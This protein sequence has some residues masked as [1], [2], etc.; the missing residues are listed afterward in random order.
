MARPSRYSE[1]FRAD[2]LRLCL[3]GDRSM[4]QIARDLGLSYWT[5]REWYTKAKMAKRKPSKTTSAEPSLQETD[6]EK[7]ARLERE[8][9]RLTKENDSLRMDR[10]ILKKAATFFAKESE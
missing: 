5:L 9:R 8:L 4:T 3:R 7:V 10:E 1:S 2:A 6:K